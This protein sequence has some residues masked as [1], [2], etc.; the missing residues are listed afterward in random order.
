MQLAAMNVITNTGSLHTHTAGSCAHAALLIRPLKHW[1]INWLRRAAG[2]E[3]IDRVEQQQQQ[4]QL[5]F[6]RSPRAI[7]GGAE[8]K[9]RCQSE[10]TPFLFFPK[11]RI[12]L[13]LDGK[14]LAAD[15]RYTYIYLCV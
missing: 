7:R 2:K 11:T 5:V 15:T 13:Q 4:Q 10:A 8:G 9:G 6:V 3:A 12:L 14:C 1:E